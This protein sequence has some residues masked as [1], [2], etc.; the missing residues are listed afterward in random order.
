MDSRIIG[1]LLSGFAVK[2]A[3]AALAIYVAVQVADYVTH[4][5]SA[6]NAGMAAL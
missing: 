6:V 5:F 1:Q 4:V 3:G 2:A